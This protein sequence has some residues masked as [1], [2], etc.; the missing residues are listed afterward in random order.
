MGKDQEQADFLQK[1]SEA[2]D[3]KTWQDPVGKRTKVF[4]CFEGTIAHPATLYGSHWAEQKGQ[5]T[6][7][8]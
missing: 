1:E 7:G 6:P 3:S 5:R 2:K 4:I 8:E